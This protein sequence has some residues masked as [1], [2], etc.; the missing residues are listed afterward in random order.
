MR[1]RILLVAF[2]LLAAGCASGDNSGDRPNLIEASRW[3]ARMRLV[4]ALRS[5]KLKSAP[6]GAASQLL[7]AKSGVGRVLVILV[8]FGGPDTLEFVPDGANKSTWDPIGKADYDEWT[9]TVGDCSKIVAKYNIKGPTKYTYQGPVHNQIEIPRSA[10]DTSGTTFWT[11]DRSPS[12]VHDMLFGNGV[13]LQY[14]RQDGSAVDQDLTGFSVRDYFLDMSGGTYAIAGDV[15]GWVKVPHS[16]YWYGADPCPGRNSG[17]SSGQHN[18]AIPG[19]GS[20][21]TLVKDAIGAVKAVYPNFDWAQYDV[22]KDGIIDHLWIVPAGVDESDYTLNSRT[23]YA[24]G[25]MWAHAGDVSPMIEVSAG[26]KAGPYIMMSESSGP[27]TYAHEYG[28]NL[29]AID[30]YASNGG[31]DS[32]GFWSLMSDDWVGYPIL[33]QAS[34]FD[35]WHLDFWGWLSPKVITDTSKEYVVR[36]GQAGNFPGGTALERAVKIS[37]TD[38]HDDFGA[39]PMGRYYWWGGHENLT[40]SMMTMVNP[41]SVP[42]GA[43]LTFNLAYDIEK[44]WDFLWV[45]ASSDGGNTWT[46]LTN[47]HTTCVHDGD[48]IGGEKNFPSDLCTAKIGGFSGKS[49]D[50][51]AMNLETFDLA[52]FAG[53][54]TLIRFW[55]MTDTLTLGDGAYIDNV[56]IAA[57]TQVAFNDDAEYGDTKWKYSGTWQR[58][59]GYSTYQHAF[60]L[61]WRNVGAEG[62][63]D[64]GLGNPMWRFGPANTGMLVWYNNDKYA[65][66]EVLNHLQHAPSFGPKGKMLV[67]DSHPDPYLDPYDVAR[68]F[69]GGVA[70]VDARAQMR[71]APFSLRDTVA[72]TMQPGWGV[73]E[74]TAFSSRPAVS[75]FSD[76]Q[77]YYP[78]FQYLLGGPKESAKKW[79]AAQWD[80]SVVMPSKVP[81]A[82]KAP[83]AKPGETMYYDSGPYYD[84]GTIWSRY[85][86]VLGAA[87]GNGNPS[88]VGGQ[89]G[90]NAQVLY[91][92]DKAGVVQIWNGTTN[93]T[94]AMTN[95]ATFEAGAVAPGEIVTIFGDQISAPGLTRM[96]LDP[97]GYVVKILAETRVLFDGVAAPLI[98]VSQNQISAVAPYSI[99]GKATTDL[100]V[101]YKG[102][103][104][105]K[106]VLPVVA[107]SPGLFTL[108]S[109]GSGQGAILNQDYTVNGS[110]NAAASDSIVILYGT[111][112]GQTS[113]AGVDG[114]P[115]SGTY[116]KPLAAV[117]VTIGGKAADILYAGAAP[118]F[119]AGVYQ[120]NAQV[121]KGLPAGAAQIKVKIG[122]NESP[123]GV[124]V[125][126]K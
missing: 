24:E 79:I 81:Y 49:A 10:S 103:L 73:T 38:G 77:S 124:T 96:A 28:H 27:A 45:Q 59:E 5:G 32:T 18:G 58:S 86:Y 65:D 118:D 9:G 34:A 41:V 31:K 113:P 3:R 48:W 102:Q 99:S 90:W 15:V 21:Q 35:P 53:K 7:E 4:E 71:D 76:S 89:Y 42:A 112:E 14:T 95:G 51:P 110:S 47:T 43:S 114:K 56:R 78:G 22:D 13:R 108:N 98:Y 70:A 83:G 46:T 40:D 8:E 80:S 74:T 36:L 84:S 106:V 125:A 39:R 16:L 101:E 116:P 111:G 66:N 107:T 91:Q 115:A 75:K 50:Y 85:S 26:V 60:F 25:A 68:G 55:Y 93:L 104:T 82:V 62:G 29:G 54:Q 37:L 120:I 52:A 44:S 87:G 105:K 6:M 17:S 11:K 63:V 12:F 121:P 30:L 123:D 23:E 109:S 88:D 122:E 94:L 61:Q 92:K 20:A 19:A 2:V 69:P 100:Q 57:G 64:R 97:N 72:F 1:H 67:V 126:V 119:V 117:S 33:G